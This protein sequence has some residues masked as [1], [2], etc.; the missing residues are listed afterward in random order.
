MNLFGHLVN[1]I[2]NNYDKKNFEIKAPR[3]LKWQLSYALC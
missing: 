1:M 3:A 2:W